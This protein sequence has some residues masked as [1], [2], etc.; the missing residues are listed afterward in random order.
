MSR[1]MSVRVLALFGLLLSAA[2]VGAAP[3]GKTSPDATATPYLRENGG[4]IS[5]SPV[6]FPLLLNLEPPLPPPPLPGDKILFYPF[7]EDIPNPERGF[8]KQSSIP[9]DQPLDAH[10]IIAKQPTDTVAWIYFFLDKY[11][12]VRDGKGVNLTDYRGRLLE[13]IGSGIGLDTV[14]DSFIEARKKGLKLVIRFVYVGYPGIGSTK[15][16]NQTEPD[17]PLELVLQHI[18]QL[19]PL[20]QENKDV[21]VAVQTGFI[22]YWG[23]W[24]SSKYMGDLA[25]RKAVLEAVLAAV[26]Q[27]R[28]IMLRYPRYKQL[29]YGGPLTDAQAYSQSNLA[30]IGIHDDAFLKDEIDDG[31]FKSNTA[32]VKITDYCDGYPGGE[33]QCWRDYVNLDTRFTPVG[34]EASVPNSPRSDCPNALTQLANMHWS[35]QNNGFNKTLLDSWVAQ[36]CMPEIRRRLGYRFE[37]IEA[38]IPRSVKAGSSFTINI[39]LRNVGFAAMFNP[40]PAYLVLQGA[41]RYE[42]PLAGVD[43]RLWQ[44]GRESIIA[45]P[46]DLPQNISPGNYRVGLWLP[47]ASTTLRYNHVY[48]VRFA[49]AKVWD[50]SAGM[51][52]LLDNFYVGP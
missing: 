4:V 16:P 44:P 41:S 30:R 21:I 11:K 33:A 32:G 35:L 14:N 34:G 1:G 48:A 6:L 52:I 2:S 42:L 31:T 46:I 51:N 38:Y 22:G 10:K 49:N 23:E 15:D 18:N 36:G 7:D 29:W 43:P 45:L 20:L 12:D 17:A 5:P 26:P 39:K 25:S 28:M 24:H 3:G 50:A 13:P 37:L 40:R 19:A 27:D 9:V 8:M 47:D